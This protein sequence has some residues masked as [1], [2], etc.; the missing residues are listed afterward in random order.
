[1]CGKRCKLSVK[2]LNQPVITGVDLG[3]HSVARR[4]F[5]LFCFFQLL[6]F[7]HVFFFVW[8]YAC[9]LRCFLHDLRVKQLL[10]DGLCVNLFALILAL[11]DVNMNLEL[12]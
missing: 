1:M 7:V 2:S 4:Y 3:F 12:E 6:I 8:L 11:C 10:L 5:E 9:V